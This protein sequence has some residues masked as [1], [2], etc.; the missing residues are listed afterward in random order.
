MIASVKKCAAILIVGLAAVTTSCADIHGSKTVDTAPAAEAIG[1]GPG[2]FTGKEG[3][4]VIY[5]HVWGGAS[6]HG[7][8]E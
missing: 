6:P 4:F 7:G 3:A 2:L 5:D 8:A 1:H